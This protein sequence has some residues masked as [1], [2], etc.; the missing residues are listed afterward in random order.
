MG[1]TPKSTL[2]SII[3][4]NSNL[5][6]SDIKIETY[7]V[8]V[9]VLLHRSQSRIQAM[10][11]RIVPYYDDHCDDLT[12]PFLYFYNLFGLNS[13]DSYNCLIQMEMA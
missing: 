7:F 10:N 6:T 13:R 11:K 4:F 12:A 8:F 3:F 5:T 1:L 2:G 9:M